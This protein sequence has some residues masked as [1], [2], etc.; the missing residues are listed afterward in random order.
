M[1]TLDTHEIVENLQAAGMPKPQAEA[2]MRAIKSREITP[3]PSWSPRTT[4]RPSGP[5]WRP[6]E[7]S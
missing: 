2:V 7:M 1:T 6:F 3:S 4:S 5:I